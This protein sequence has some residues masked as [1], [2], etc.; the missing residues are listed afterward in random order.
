MVADVHNLVP[1]IGELNGDRSNF[2]FGMLEGESRLYG[3]CDFEVN[4]KRK[5][6]EPRV[7]VRGDVARTYF[8][9][10]DTYNIRISRKQ[11]KLFNVWSSLDPVSVLECKKNKR[12][13][14][15]QGNSNRYVYESC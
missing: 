12:I 1:A 4:F 3:S 6:A 2:R 15:I 11:T 13:E 7:S 10:R 5:I 14:V 8:Y 9:M